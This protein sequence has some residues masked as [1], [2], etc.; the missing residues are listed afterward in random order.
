MVLY[1]IGLSISLIR[2]T[3][4]S[5]ILLDVIMNII[6]VLI[7]FQGWSFLLYRN[8][9]D[10]FFIFGKEERLAQKLPART[11]LAM[12]NA[13]LQF[14]IYVA[15]PSEVASSACFH[16]A[17]SLCSMLLSESQETLEKERTGTCN[18]SAPGSGPS[19]VEL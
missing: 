18:S 2:I 6:T 12:A 13:N 17:S 9:T 16:F 7:S 3:Q 4:N 8:T 14:Q 5:L 15:K 11:Q 10:D 1:V 19:T